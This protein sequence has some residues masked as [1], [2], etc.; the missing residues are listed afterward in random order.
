MDLLDG[1]TD[2]PL[3]L[4]LSVFINVRELR[5]TVLVALAATA[6]TLIL[7]TGFY[8]R[9]FNYTVI[10]VVSPKKENKVS[11]STLPYRFDLFQDPVSFMDKL[12]LS[13]LENLIPYF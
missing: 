11:E 3:R 1:K 4:W 5:V 12:L 2:W 13:H 10:I 7:L 6:F 9:G 8:L